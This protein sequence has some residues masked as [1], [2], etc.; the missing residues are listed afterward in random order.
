M[1]HVKPFPGPIS[2]C[3]G[4]P[5]RADTTKMYEKTFAAGKP[6]CF[7]S[8]A[9]GPDA[10]AGPGGS[11]KDPLINFKAAPGMSTFSAT[12]LPIVE[13]P[14]PPPPPPKKEEPK[15]E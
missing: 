11:P 5:L 10:C 15:A 6:K 1:Q 8:G 2:L 7:S 12:G 3:S 9:A 4:C 14:K 13:A